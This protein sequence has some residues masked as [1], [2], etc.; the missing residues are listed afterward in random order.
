MTKFLKKEL[1]RYQVAEL[2]LASSTFHAAEAG[3]EAH[4]LVTFSVERVSTRILDIFHTNISVKMD[5][6]VGAEPSAD[7][8]FA[9]VIDW[10][11]APKNR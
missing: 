2:A 6:A 4:D 5:S 3:Q 8:M 7:Q 10:R 9:P 11:R 1:N